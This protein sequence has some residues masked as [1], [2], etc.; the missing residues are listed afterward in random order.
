[1]FGHHT[2]CSGNAGVRFSGR[3]VANGIKK[4]LMATLIFYYSGPHG[5]SKYLRSCDILH[6]AKINGMVINISEVSWLYRINV[7]HK[8]CVDDTFDIARSV[9]KP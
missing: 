9:A 5:D 7:N 3:P 4:W 6:A 1:M 8:S 2:N